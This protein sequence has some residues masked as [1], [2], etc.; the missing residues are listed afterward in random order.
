MYAAVINVL[1]AFDGVRRF[2]DA[3]TL[4]ESIGNIMERKTG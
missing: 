2:K 1:V 4:A 3:V